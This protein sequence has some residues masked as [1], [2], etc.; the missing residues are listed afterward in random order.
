MEEPSKKIRK[1]GA[2]SQN[3]GEDSEFIAVSNP[4]VS[5]L[6]SYQHLKT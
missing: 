5:E 4:N 3:N 6:T 2:G 1:V